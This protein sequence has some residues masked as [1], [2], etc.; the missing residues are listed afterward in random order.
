MLLGND[1]VESDIRVSNEARSLLG[2]GYDITCMVWNRAG[3]KGRERYDGI[4]IQRIPLKAPFGDPRGSLFLYILLFNLNAFFNLLLADFDVIH[5]H[6]FDTLLPGLLAGKIKRK[7]VVYDA[8]EIYALMIEP[9]LPGIIVRML[10]AVEFSLAKKVDCLITVNEILVN[11]FESGIGN[12]NKVSLIMN[13]K[14]RLDFQFSE[15]EIRNFRLRWGI[16]ACFIILHNGWLV[17]GNG[18]E[19][20]FCAIERLK[21]YSKEDIMVLVCGNG[22]AEERLKEI[23]KI[24]HLENYVQFTGA[25]SSKEVPLFVNACDL[26]Y[27][28][29]NKGIK[30]SSIRTPSRLFEAIVSGK[31]VLA[32]NFG[33]L[34]KMVEKGEIGLTVNPENPDELCAAILEIKQQAALRK[35]FSENAKKLAEI[36]NW[37]SEEKKLLYLYDGLMQA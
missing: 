4:K 21:T 36:Y 37:S 17:S 12:K 8:H 27:I 5:C 13:C 18:L 26:M 20:L 23:V 34:K 10:S 3:A 22:F 31:P 19:E 29:Y 32:S 28:V 2:K 16:D 6:D 30:Y 33:E 9:Y 11:Y 1:G 25:I 15:K 24:K 7:K 14:N 35:R